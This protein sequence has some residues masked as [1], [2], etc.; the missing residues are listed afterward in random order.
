MTTAQ[1]ETRTEPVLR[2]RWHIVGRVQGVGF[3]PLVYRLAHKLQIC[4]AVWNDA[5]G[6]IAEGQGTR[7]QLDEFIVALR[8]EAPAA[9]VIRQIIE[10]QI[11]LHDDGEQF[12]I[13]HTSQTTTPTAEVAVDM[14]ICPACLAE[15]RD[16]AN[17][18]R[19]GYALTNCTNCGPRFGIIRAIP[20]DR[21]NTTMADFK[22]CPPCCREYEDPTDR[23]F[24]AQP[25][26]CRDCGPQLQ[27]LDPHGRRIDEDPIRGAARRLLH[28]KIVAVKGIGGFHLAVRADDQ[29][30][31]VRLRQL[32]H[33]PAKPF[34][35]MC[36]S[37]NSVHQLIRLSP[38]GAT[39]IASPA[40]PIILAPR[41]ADAPIAPAVAPGQH[42]LGVMLAYTPLH[43]LIFDQLQRSGVDTL[44]MT[45]GNDIDEPL[46]FDDGDAVGRLG[47]LCDAILLH[48]RPIQRA[49]DDSVII[50][51]RDI[52]IFVRRARGYVPTPIALPPACDMA[53]GLAVG[54]ELKCTVATCRGGQ[55]ILSQHLGN[56]T[57]A[58]TFDAF[59]QAIADL[60][61]LFSVAPRWIA[62]DLHPAYLSTQHAR[63]L[64]AQ[65][66]V[67]LVGVQHHHAHAAAVLAEHGTTG[68]ALAVVCDGTGFG[69]D[70]T[71]WGGE[72]LVA[73]LA[74]F[75]R[76]GRLRPMLL[77]GGDACAKQPWRSALALL[78]MACGSE[79][80]QLPIVRRLAEPEQL[81]FVRQMLRTRVSCVRSSSTGR[82][83]D[84]VAA[85][86]NLCRENRFDAEAP[87]ALEAAAQSG[88][89]SRVW[90][91][92]YQL[93]D[94]DGLIEIDLTPLVQKVARRAGDDGSTGDLAMLF[95]QTLAAAW[96]AAIA[97][98]M[99]K[100][101]LHTV[102]L[103]GGV[104][105]N[106][107]FADL[108]SRRLEVL[109][110][111]I[112]R[113]RAIPPNDGGIAFGQAA[114]ASAR[115][116]QGPS[117]K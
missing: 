42:R 102:A 61:D 1:S 53:P 71:I 88:H 18:R 78:H 19:H 5:E 114:V 109:G 69:I 34:A 2:C 59:K 76:I 115:A 113:H 28:G 64:A 16:T 49:V 38:R 15:I 82:L 39:L 116:K 43:H 94:V 24:H 44:V 26:A 23:R 11:P 112:L 110:V 86:L 99:R 36:A 46:A 106:E 60:C 74:D 32:K 51:V 57:R 21:I 30:A 54:A 79:F 95:H 68:P 104:F 70:G 25:T 67:P 58:R 63:Q 73:S 98:A 14:A 41:A 85:L 89:S 103:S 80:S 13:R 91:D 37:L 62:H 45:S 47:E 17:H 6:V 8:A 9:A 27:L 3:R 111:Q 55:V 65:W 93:K 101:D 12:E 105:C 52:S 75:R 81:E 72:L 20:Y 107:L 35:L 48:D 84:G 77:P 96:T 90:E 87:M 66:R 10:Q 83:F 7:G 31:V 4:G 92:A 56:L 97:Q 100:T 50:D 40:A 22:M 33:R 29:P 108:L 117:G